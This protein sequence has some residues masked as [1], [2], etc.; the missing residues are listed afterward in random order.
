MAF[1]NLLRAL[2]KVLTSSYSTEKHYDYPIEILAMGLGGV[3]YVSSPVLFCALS[4]SSPCIDEGKVIAN[5]GEV[6][7][8]TTTR[9]RTQNKIK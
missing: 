6:V 8:K 1:S 3:T 7:R 4:F 2:T 5:A 9:E